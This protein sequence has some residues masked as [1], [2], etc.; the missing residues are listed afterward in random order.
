MCAGTYRQHIEHSQIDIFKPSLMELAVII[1]M[2]LV[3]SDFAVVLWAVAKSQAE[4]LMAKTL[5]T[6]G[7]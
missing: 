7:I 4:P 1:M 2:T 6:D 3:K 5:V